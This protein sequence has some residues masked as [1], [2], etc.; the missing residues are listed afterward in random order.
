MRVVTW[1]CCEGLHRKHPHLRALDFDVA[2]VSEAGPFQLER[3]RSAH[4]SHV[5]RLAV[6][7]PGQTKEIAVL[8]RSPWRVGCLPDVTGQPW[9]MPVKVSGPVDVT[10]LAVWTLGREWTAERLSYTAQLARVIDEVLPAVSGPVFL[11]GDLNA[12]IASTQRAHDANVARLEALGLVSAYT[13]ARRD[14]DPLSEPTHFHQ[15]QKDR[16]FHIDHVFLPKEW[17]DGIEVT[18]GSYDDWVATKLSDHVPVIVD[19][20]LPMH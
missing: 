14:A 11:A 3:G 16:G 10:V 13:A 15:R 17:S 19:V 12:P 6:D 1:N 8:A 9:V 4:V 18:V 20:P 2:V 7:Q 5:S